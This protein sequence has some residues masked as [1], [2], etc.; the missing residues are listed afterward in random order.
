MGLNV[1]YAE[2]FRGWLCDGCNRS[3]GMLSISAGGSDFG[4]LINSLRYIIKSE[5]DKTIKSEMQMKLFELI[6]FVN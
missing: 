1:K 2:K 6:D 5:N 3:I 4:G